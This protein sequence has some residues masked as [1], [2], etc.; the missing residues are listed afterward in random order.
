[1][2]NSP[3]FDGLRWEP[4]YPPPRREPSGRAARARCAATAVGDDPT[5][6]ATGPGFLG[7]LEVSSVRFCHGSPESLID[8]FSPN[9]WIEFDRWISIEITIG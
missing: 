6:T 5:T 8:G 2:V 3:L 4:H 1:M 7:S 9:S